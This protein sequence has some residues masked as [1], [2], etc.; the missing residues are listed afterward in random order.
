MGRLRQKTRLPGRRASPIDALPEGSRQFRD[1]TDQRPFVGLGVHFAVEAGI[2]QTGED[3]L[4]LRTRLQ[5]HG[6]QVVAG[7]NRSD[8]LVDR[9][10]RGHVALDHVRLGF[11]H[12]QQQGFDRQWRQQAIGLRGSGRGLFRQSAQ[13]EVRRDVPGSNGLGMAFRD[14]QPR[15]GLAHRLAGSPS[16]RAMI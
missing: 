1:P 14:R 3:L 16:I 13:D 2:Q 4:E 11:G 8:M 9:E 15:D 12:E 6:L 10:E 7:Q 5:P